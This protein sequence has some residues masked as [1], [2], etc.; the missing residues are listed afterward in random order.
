MASAATR[1]VALKRSG[2]PSREAPLRVATALGLC[3]GAL[4]A[5]YKGAAGQAGGRHRTKGAAEC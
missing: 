4:A 5:R 2:Q 3:S 1:R